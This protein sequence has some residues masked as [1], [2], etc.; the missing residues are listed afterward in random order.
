M[1]TLEVLKIDII[2]CWLPSLYMFNTKQERKR[3]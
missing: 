1:N 2:H 3:G